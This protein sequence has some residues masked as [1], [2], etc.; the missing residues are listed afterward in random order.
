MQSQE[1]QGVTVDRWQDIKQVFASQ[2]GVVITTDVS[3]APV[4]FKGVKFEWAFHPDTSTL[5]I[6]VD[7]ESFIDK[8][9]GYND[10]KVLQQFAVWVDGVQ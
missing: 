9:A 2:T 6:T 4:T 7:G 8:A 1:F 3:A 5:V 10:Q